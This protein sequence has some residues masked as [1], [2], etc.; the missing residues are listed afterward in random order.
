MMV[1]YN[2]E[3][4]LCIRGWKISCCKRTKF[5]KN[6]FNYLSNLMK[7]TNYVKLIDLFL[8]SKYAREQVINKITIKNTQQQAMLRN[9]KQKHLF[10]NK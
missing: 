9:V 5:E 3:Y 7:I 2:V 8:Y 4:F 6:T 1:L 10:Y